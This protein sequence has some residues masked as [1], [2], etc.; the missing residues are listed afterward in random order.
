[1]VEDSRCR[2]RCRSCRRTA[3][4]RA[5]TR[6]L[7][8]VAEEIQTA[9]DAMRMP[10]LRQQK[11]AQEPAADIDEVGASASTTVLE[12]LLTLRNVFGK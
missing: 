6:R 2:C 9:R 10:I 1:M 4:T 12:L 3:P 7:P 11:M 5:E 8:A